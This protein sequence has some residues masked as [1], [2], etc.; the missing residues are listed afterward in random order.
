MAQLYTECL[1]L[2][3]APIMA[4]TNSSHGT[5]ELFE[6]RA[7]PLRWKPVMNQFEGLTINLAH[8]GGHALE[9]WTDESVEMMGVAEHRVFS[10]FSC[11]TEVRCSRFAALLEKRIEQWRKESPYIAARMMYGSDWY[12]LTGADILSRKGKGIGPPYLKRWYHALEKNQIPQDMV[13]NIFGRN[14]ADYLGLRDSRVLDRI[15]TF[16]ENRGIPQPR[17]R[18]RVP[19]EVPP[20]SAVPIRT[21]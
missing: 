17:W 18:S 15:D 8:F 13:A 10:D 19:H 16:L 12:M 4:H 6:M 2:H 20:S 9:S 5:S 1:G 14:A 7:A 21:A 11:F 3:S